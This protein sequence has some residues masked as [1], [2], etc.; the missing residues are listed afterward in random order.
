MCVCVCVCVRS[1]RAGGGVGGFG[2]WSRYAM[3]KGYMDSVGRGALLFTLQKLKFDIAEVIISIL[4][5]IGT[6]TT[7][8]TTTT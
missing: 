8:T 6:T 3:S 7:T 4:L 2:R 1:L 5:Q